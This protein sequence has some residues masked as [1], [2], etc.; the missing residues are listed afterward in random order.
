MT[1]APAPIEISAVIETCCAFSLLLIVGSRA[2]MDVVE[3]SCTSMLDISPTHT[4]TTYTQINEKERKAK[5]RM[6]N[7]SNNNNI[8]GK[9]KTKYANVRTLSDLNGGKDECEAVHDDRNSKLHHAVLVYKVMELASAAPVVARTGLDCRQLSHGRDGL[10]KRHV[11]HEARSGAWPN[12]IVRRSC[13][14]AT[15]NKERG[16]TASLL[17]RPKYGQQLDYGRAEVLWSAAIT[18]DA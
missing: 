17:L 1:G 12:W 4:I 16:S 15:T 8:E 5:M 7:T 11:A 13:Y 14:S 6:K 3:F 2:H 10:H 18:V 9:I